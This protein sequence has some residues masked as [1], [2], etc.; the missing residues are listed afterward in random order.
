MNLERFNLSTYFTG[1]RPESLGVSDWGIEETLSNPSTAQFS[2]NKFQVPHDPILRFPSL[3]PSTENFLKYI[4]KYLSLTL[5]NEY[6]D[7]FK[8]NLVISNL[9]DSSMILSKNE[10]NLNSFMSNKTTFDHPILVKSFNNDGTKLVVM[11]NYV[12]K[13]PYF[14]TNSYNILLVV[15]LIIY[16]LKRLKYG[17]RSVTNF[18]LFKFLLIAST[19]LIKLRRVQKLILFNSNLNLLH[20]FL[21][22]NFKINK[23]IISYLITLKNWK[24]FNKNDS[25]YN[26][27]Y[28]QLDESLSF[29]IFNSTYPI[30]HL[31]PLLNGPNLEKYCNINNIQLTEDGDR[32][33]FDDIN[34][35]V[36][37]IN[38]F[39]NYRKLLICLL[40]IFEDNFE[41]NFFLI[42]LMDQFHS[43]SASSKS[44]VNSVCKQR[45]LTTMLLN[46]NKVVDNF[47]LLFDEYNELNQLSS[48]KFN[49]EDILKLNVQESTNSN[50]SQL[51]EKMSKLSTNFK[52]FNK[53]NQSTID[54]REELTEKLM[55]FKQFKDDLNSINELYKL[56]LQELKYQVNDLD[57]ED[58]ASNSSYSNSNRNS[59]NGE[60]NLKSFH[61][62]HKRKSYTQANSPILQYHANS[63]PLVTPRQDDDSKR[64]SNNGLRLGLLTVMENEKE[65]KSRKPE[66]YNQ[67][68]LDQLSKRKTS[69]FSVNSLNSNVSGLSDIVTSQTT[70]FDDDD[71]NCLSKDELKL[72]LEDSLNK[73]YNLEK[74]SL[75]NDKFASTDT[76][77]LAGQ[78][79]MIQTPDD[80]KKP[81][82][83]NETH[84]MNFKHIDNSF[85][86]NLENNLE[87]KLNN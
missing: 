36:T 55:I 84:E 14:Y 8:Y 20:D 82:E 17:N 87:S 86:K 19:K 56:S 77:N 32:R 58:L 34:N 25:D 57:N 10:S 39:N 2:Y 81:I 30:T 66:E 9:L 23:K 48:D 67:F 76:L 51:I 1:E 12:I 27:L 59:V 46:Y 38:K 37:K 52:F 45:I 78:E 31:L 22:Q 41:S 71:A 6:Y 35:I 53:Y 16:L 43:K 24:L 62:K 33:A 73:L 65:V 60:F 75:S 26:S 29:L 64:L 63:T 21:I 3:Q 69:R 5:N 74:G 50:C 72:R 15:N 70:S 42:K 28:K 79:E 83:F 54:N 18:R 7:K 85:L 47:N 44:Y 4:R 80:L 13:F 49:D 11:K 40:L 61:T 68:T